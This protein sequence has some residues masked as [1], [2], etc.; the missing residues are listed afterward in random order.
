[1]CHGTLHRLFITL[2]RGVIMG[3]KS[4]LCN[5][6]RY[7]SKITSY[8]TDKPHDFLKIASVQHIFADLNRDSFSGTISNLKIIEYSLNRVLFYNANGSNRI[9]FCLHEWFTLWINPSQSG[10]LFLSPSLCY[11]AG[12]ICLSANN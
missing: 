10:F 4:W 5:C 3:N 1:M 11:R 9:H 12:A 8:K 6:S 7:S 2:L